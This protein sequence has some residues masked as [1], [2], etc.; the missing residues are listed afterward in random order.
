M[1]KKT[2]ISIIA[3]IM[4]LA[5][6]AGIG[7]VY[8]EESTGKPATQPTSSKPSVEQ[9]LD[10]MGSWKT[11]TNSQYGY[12]V[13]YPEGWYF[14][15]YRGATDDMLLSY[16]VFSDKPLSSERGEL[17]LL[18]SIVI[19]VENRAFEEAR[20]LFQYEPLISPPSETEVIVGE[21]K[22]LKQ[23]GVVV[24]DVV[25]KVQEIRVLIP[26]DNRVYT[27]VI[28]GGT[29]LSVFDQMLSTFR[30]TD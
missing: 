21:V 22:A 2:I 24:G 1:T 9:E 30:F 18:Q 5:L 10:S 16:V 26:Q 6:I 8:K 17:E 14:K 23:S 11:Y 20:S 19:M 28:M 15:D 7:L 3:V 4:G 29:H 12:S 13:K 25:G 27:L